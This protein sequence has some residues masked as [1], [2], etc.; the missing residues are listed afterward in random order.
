[1]MLVGNIVLLLSI[2]LSNIMRNWILMHISMR[3]NISLISDYLIKLMKLPVTFFENKLV[4]DILQRA[5][6]HERI[7]SFI[8]NNSLSTL[9]SAVTFVVFSIILLVYNSGIFF[10]FLAGNA[11]YVIWVLTFLSVRKKLDWEY[12]ELNSKNQ[13]FWVE[14]IGNIQEIKINKL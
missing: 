12:F 5:N 14:T 7:R 10:I 6:D 9:F 13:S 2:T 4:G 3:V 11:L 8:M 1:M